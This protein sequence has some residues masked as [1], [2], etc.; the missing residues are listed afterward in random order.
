M[1]SRTVAAVLTLLPLG[2]A[3]SAQTVMDGTE[4]NIPPEVKIALFDAVRDELRDGYTARLSDLA[5]TG[6]GKICGSINGKNAYGAYAGKV[7]FYF[8][9]GDGS[10]SV[11]PPPGDPLYD[12]QKTVFR[13]IGCPRHN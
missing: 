1:L 5:P 10:L 13:A 9:P 4:T 3:A 11:M 12:L 8:K 6:T 7:R 2:S